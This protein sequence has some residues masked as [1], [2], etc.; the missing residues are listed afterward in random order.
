MQSS[1]RTNIDLPNIRKRQTYRNKENGA[2]YFDLLFEDKSDVELPFSSGM[3]QKEN[4]LKGRHLYMVIGLVLVIA[5]CFLVV[6]MVT[7]DP[8]V[9]RY[10]AVA[11]SIEDVTIEENNVVKQVER[12]KNVLKKP[13]QVLSKKTN[14][15]IATKPAYII[16][17]KLLPVTR[18]KPQIL[19]LNKTQTKVQEVISGIMLRPL[20]VHSESPLRGLSKNN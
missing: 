8:K 4:F 10:E 19:T 7:N 6:Q 12:P 18:P 1:Q 20:V 3:R 2:D 9:E 13:A 15:K 5:T 17:Q 14:Q 16:V 11:K